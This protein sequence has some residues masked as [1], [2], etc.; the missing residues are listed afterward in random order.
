MTQHKNKLIL[1]SHSNV[2]PGEMQ[3]ITSLFEAGLECLHIRKPDFLKEQVLRFIEK[4]PQE[5]HNRLM[6]H[7]HYDMGQKF[8]LQGIHFTANKRSFIPAYAALPIRKSTSCHTY[9]EVEEYKDSVDYIFLSP[10]FKSISKPGYLGTFKEDELKTFLS[11]PRK[12]E[13]YALGGID[14]SNIPKAFELGFSGVAIHGALWDRCR[15]NISDAIRIYNELTA[16][17]KA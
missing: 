9:N 12:A 2:M 4:I 10:I 17:C 3:I 8:E 7:S 5:F 6:I 11:T 13:I 16:L 14:Q 1:I 15:G